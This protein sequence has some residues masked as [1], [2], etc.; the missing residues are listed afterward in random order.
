MSRDLR[1]LLREAAE[2][3]PVALGEVEAVRR[4]GDSLRRQRRLQM[5]LAIGLT[6]VVAASLMPLVLRG[7]SVGDILN[8]APIDQPDGS[9]KTDGAPGAE[10]DAS[11]DRQRRGSSGAPAGSAPSGG[12]PLGGSSSGPTSGEERIVFASHRD[13][14]SHSEIYTMLPDGGGVRRLTNNEVSD[15]DDTQPAWSPDGTRIAYA[16]G[17]RGYRIFVM[18]ADGSRLLTDADADERDP[19]WSPDG[20]RIVFSQRSRSSDDHDLVVADV[21]T[22]ETTRLTNTPEIDEF[23]AAWSPDGSQIAY[24]GSGPQ[25][26]GLYVV[27]SDGSGRRR[28]TST[29]DVNPAWSPDGRRI[30]FARFVDD[31][32]LSLFVMDADGSGVRRLTN[33]PNVWDYGPDWSPDGKQ[34]MFT[35]DPDGTDQFDFV[36]ATLDWAARAP[37]GPEAGPL[38][39][40][41]LIGADG[42]EL[43]QLTDPS[44]GDFYADWYSPLR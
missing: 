28:L 37:A 40:I 5:A 44:F 19:A 7:S 25:L 29:P 15:L 18:D 21:S 3:P 6:I 10:S 16:S 38:S 41:H 14:R 9:Q 22:G 24:E 36:Y 1:Q 42:K 27:R 23:G 33:D 31:G 2:S 32:I 4:R 11:R 35:R 30:A 26:E 17:A 12:T 8:I 34:I 13:N 20:T 43:R 39:S